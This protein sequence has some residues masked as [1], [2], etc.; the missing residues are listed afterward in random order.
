MSY[1]KTILGQAILETTIPKKF[2]DEFISVYKTEG[3]K[4]KKANSQLAGK[5]KKE[6]QLYYC[7][8]DTLNN[9]L[10]D[11]ILNW[12]RFQ[13]RTY[14]IMNKIQTMTIRLSSIWI[15]EMFANEYNPV[16]IH[17]SNTPLYRE[18][19]SSV[20][21]IKLPES[22]GE[23]YSRDDDPHNGKLQFISSGGGQFSR[24][25]YYPKVEVGNMYIFPYDLRHCVYP[26]NTTKDSRI[27]VAGNCDVIFEKYERD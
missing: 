19:L 16:H 2:L 24:G 5:I 27:T 23:E 20:I 15:N 14:L 6:F 18:G 22:Y 8:K 7:Y 13:F 1:K 10:S 12:Y 17:K 25:T 3:E 26:F 4:L 11:E 9:V 21:I